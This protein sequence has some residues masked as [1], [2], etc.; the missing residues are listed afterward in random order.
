MSLR[1][2]RCPR[3]WD[4]RPLSEVQRVHP[5]PVCHRPGEQG[6]WVQLGWNI[7]EL[8][9]L[10]PD[11]R[12]GTACPNSSAC[13]Q[14]PFGPDLQPRALRRSGVAGSG[15]AALQPH[16]FHGSSYNSRDCS[17]RPCCEIRLFRP[18]AQWG[19][20]GHTPTWI[21]PLVKL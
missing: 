11:S 5:W 17:W 20:S 10:G 4:G 3:P 6:P 16:A 21:D 15:L 18:Q 12:V 9:V 19:A 13:R 7:R 1:C 2:T 8:A 14:R